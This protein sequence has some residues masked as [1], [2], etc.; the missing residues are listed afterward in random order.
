MDAVNATLLTFA[1]VSDDVAATTKKLAKQSILSAYFRTL[2]DADLKLAVRFSSGHVFPVISDIVLNVGSATLWPILLSLLKVPHDDFRQAVISSGEIGEAISTLWSADFF[3]ESSAMLTLQEIAY[4]FTQLAFCSNTETKREVLY[5]LF[6]NC[7]DPR[8]AAY[9][10][11]IIFGDL[12]TGV[13]EGVLQASIAEAFTEPLSAVQRAQ[14][15]IGDLEE[16]AILAKHHK[17]QDAKFALFHPLQFMLATPV[18]TPLEAAQII[19]DRSAGGPA[20]PFYCEDKLDGIRAQVHKAGS[21]I[22]IYTRTMDRTDES[23]P[24]VIAQFAHVAGDFLLDGEI[25]PY[26]GDEVLP[27]A[28]LQRRLGRKTLSRRILEENPCRFIA[29][30]LLYLNGRLLTDEPLRARRGALDELTCSAAPGSE[31][32][33]ATAVTEVAAET[34]I[35]AAFEASRNRRNEGIILKD[36]SSPYSFGR[37]G[38]HWLKLKTHLPTLDCVVTAAEYG[39][40]KRRNVLSDYTF[41]VWSA[42]PAS[43]DGATLL[44][45]GKSFTGLTDA[46]IAEY[47]KTFLDLSVSNNGRVHQVQ[48]KIVLEIAFDQIQKSAR[49]PSGYALRLPRIK[50]IRTDK[51]PREADT[52]VRVAEIYA[53]QSNFAKPKVE[54]PEPPPEPTLFDHL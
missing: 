37:R 9:L 32:L 11:K 49:H 19:V 7:R 13:Q 48:P 54:K 8:E 33:L 18:E 6:S 14:M 26:A 20:V 53:S 25:V 31:S 39:H 42:D 30:D 51:L 52:I 1:R 29:F 46:E 15:L 34:D 21:T 23:F 5:R 41:A 43:D 45:I 10:A 4:T 27:F 50:R 22:H 3:A 35:A 36:P 38:Q 2:E 16:V 40:G 17:L 44:N 28:H 12:R 47:T 24:D